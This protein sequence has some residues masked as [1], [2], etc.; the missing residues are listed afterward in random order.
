[1]IERIEHDSLGDIAVPANSYWGAVTERAFEH[2]QI[3][4]ETMPKEIIRALV[5][6]KR[7]AAFVNCELGLLDSI[8][9]EA[10]IKA[11]NQIII[12][13]KNDNDFP[14]KVWQTGS[15]TQ[16]N[17]NVNEVIANICKLDLGVDVH[18]NDDVNMGQS[19]NDTFSSAI[20]I[21]A[22]TVLE[23]NLKKIL[24]ELSDEFTKIE[25]KYGDIIKVGRTH[26]QDAT[27]IRFGDE[28][29]AW[30]RAVSQGS[31][32]IE[33]MSKRLAKLALG[34]T[35]VGTGINSHAEFGVRMAQRI[36]DS[37]GVDFEESRNKYYQISSKDAI[38]AFHSSLKDLATSLY[39]IAN[40][41]RWLSSGPRCGL[42]E[43][44]IPANEPG[45]SIMPGKI[46]PTQA[47]A[48]IQCC[49]Q[50]MGNDTAVSFA[51]ASGN[52]EL[53]VCMPMIAYNV[54]QSL[55]ILAGSIQMFTKYLVRG[56]K[57]NKEK[58]DEN[59]AKSLMLV[60]N[61]SPVL[62]YEKSAQVAKHASQ[63]NLTI[64]EAVVELTELNEEEINELLNPEKMV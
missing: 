31:K 2:F 55:N 54:L 20:H 15:G 49:I 6:I 9:A 48:L 18:P 41:I 7:E 50:V 12:E 42:E 25:E 14:L 5:L 8:K 62:G 1:M 13:R 23:H 56:M 33:V 30:R 53:N 17:M 52:F 58:M 36:S 47:E 10:I 34:G 11:A 63:N 44:I 27:P 16:T 26:L 51:G 45:S 61:L 39:K 21:A 60:T 59:L 37:I 19:T 64:K 3:S 57:P 24:L 32:R 38:V 22:R 46:N 40:D 28:V 43:L 4:N 29:E 35:A